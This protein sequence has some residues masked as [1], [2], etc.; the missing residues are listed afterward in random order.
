MST[1]YNSFAK[2]SFDVAL[3]LLVLPIAMVAVTMGAML[4]LVTTGKSFIYTQER[5][6]RDGATFTMY[7]LRTLKHDAS[8]DYSGMRPNDPDVLW[9]GRFLRAWRV[10]ELPQIWNILRGDMSWVGPRPERPHIVAKCEASIPN[11]AARHE[12]LPGIT[13]LAQVANP[14]AT[15]DDNASKLQHDLEYLERASLALDVSILWKTLLAIG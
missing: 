12:M 9:V 7:K 5:I 14:D 11:Y 15:P 3:S 8:S 10:D 2:R 13:G 6:G 4:I 1:Y